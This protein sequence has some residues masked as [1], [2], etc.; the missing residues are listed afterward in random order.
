MKKSITIIFLLFLICETTGCMRVYDT[1]T[2]N[3]DGT[4]TETQKQCISKE[5]IDSIN[6]SDTS[7]NLSDSDMTLETL[8]DGGEYYCTSETK[9]V[10]EAD[11]AK[12]SGLTINKDIFYYPIQNNQDE[13]VKTGYDLSDAI[14]KNIFLKLTINLGDD[15]VETNANVTDETTGCTAVFNSYFTEQSWYA[16]TAQGK[17]IIN[18]D[19]TPPV[20]KFLQ[21]KKYYAGLPNITYTDNVGIASVTLNNKPF[22]HL[23][24]KN[25]K[26]EIKVTD[27]KG[28]ST[29]ATFTCDTVK[30]VIKG[31]KQNKSYKKKAVFYVRDKVS[32]S[33]VTVDGK[34]QKISK[35]NL[36]KKGKYKK[37]YKFTIKKKGYHSI[38]ATDKAGNSYYTGVTVR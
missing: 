30:P 32:L 19:T 28:N 23:N 25:G 29:K 33:K 2:V 21:K 37:Y 5:Y 17:E 15:I 9:T 38:I 1:L 34:K 35:K 7:Q 24:I 36:V 12:S 13:S 16:Y 31:I 4:V 10:S 27:I 11:A 22:T 3:P 6:E 18:S 8:E 20:I 14:D 26:N